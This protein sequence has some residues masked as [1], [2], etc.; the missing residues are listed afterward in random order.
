MLIPTHTYVPRTDTHHWLGTAVLHRLPHRQE[1]ETRGG[2]GQGHNH[3]PQHKLTCNGAR[4]THTGL[5][6][7]TC[8]GYQE[9]GPSTVWGGQ[10]G[11][12]GWLLHRI[13]HTWWREGRMTKAFTNTRTHAR[14]HAHTHCNNPFTTLECNGLECCPISAPICRP[15]SLTPKDRWLPRT[16]C[17]CPSFPP[18]CLLSDGSQTNNRPLTREATHLVEGGE[19]H[20]HARRH[21]DRQTHAGIYTPLNTPHTSHTHAHTTHTHTYT[22]TTPWLECVLHTLRRMEG[23]SMHNPVGKVGVSIV[24]V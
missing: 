2:M 19:C 17:P 7:H 14:T 11:W 1:C 16:Q 4:H 5:A 12:A 13:Q 23:G 3:L 22:A 20:M 18:A 10:V 24:T 15:F 6:L 21:T 9:E 8:S